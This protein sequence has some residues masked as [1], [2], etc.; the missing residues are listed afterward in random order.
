MTFQKKSLAVACSLALACMGARADQL[1]DMQQKLDTLQKEMDELKAQMGSVQK[2]Q[3]Q[4]A[5]APAISMKP[6]NDLTFKVGGGEV[7]I[8]GHADVSLDYVTNGMADFINNGQRV[9]G[10]NSWMFDVSSTL[11]Y[12]AILGERAVSNDLKGVFQFETEDAYASTP[13]ASNQGTDATAQ[14]R[15][16]RA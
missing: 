1:S 4:V 13:G 2:K 11:S 12:F 7:T 6:G 3:E 14:K 5:P 10:H 16:L 15:S 9:T 8:Y